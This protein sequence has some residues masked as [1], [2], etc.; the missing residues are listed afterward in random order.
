MGHFIGYPRRYNQGNDSCRDVNS[1]VCSR[2]YGWTAHDL[3]DPEIEREWVKGA[4]EIVEGVLTQMPP[5]YFAEGKALFRLMHRITMHVGDAAGNFALQVEIII[6]ETM[7]ARADTAFLTP[8]DEVRQA[9]AALAAGRPDPARTRILIP[10]T[11][12]IESV[13][14]GHELH[15]HRTK[16][17]WYAEFGIPNYWILDVFNRSL[18][19]LVLQ[20][21]TYRQDALGRN[22]DHL[23]S[24]LFPKLAIDLRELWPMA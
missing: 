20:D 19:C 16:R 22:E 21:Q 7:L 5:A 23:R 8:L 13:S 14:P 10:P 18:E 4:Y 15:D 2:H 1:P 9:K 24:S 11:L 6:N 17:R 12:V 3:D